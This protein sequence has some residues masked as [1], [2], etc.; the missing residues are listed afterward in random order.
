M[1]MRLRR[2]LSRLRDHLFALGKR[3]RGLIGRYRPL[4]AKGRDELLKLR[5]QLCQ[6]IIAGLLVA[7]F[8][9]P[10]INSAFV[11]PWWIYAVAGIAVLV[12]LLTSHALMRYIQPD[13]TSK[14]DTQ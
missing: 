4:T 6:N 2:R 8:I 5:A 9:T 3:G 12:L 11:V 10:V 1:V 14:E 7:V 13:D